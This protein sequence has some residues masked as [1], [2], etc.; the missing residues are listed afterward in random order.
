MAALHESLLPCLSTPE[1]CTLIVAKYVQLSTAMVQCTEGLICTI[2]LLF[3]SCM[4]A[5]HPQHVALESTDS[6]KITYQAL[7]IHAP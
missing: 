2:V 4:Y 3:Q 6:I 5:L 7:F 1:Y